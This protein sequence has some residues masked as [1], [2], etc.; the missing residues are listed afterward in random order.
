MDTRILG[1]ILCLCVYLNLVFGANILL[2]THLQ[3]SHLLEVSVVS[4]TLVQRG[5]KVYTVLPEISK[6]VEKVKS[7]GIEVITYTSRPG[8]FYSDYWI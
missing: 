6:H 4:E 1:C 2:L 8:D 7:R 5:H 3:P